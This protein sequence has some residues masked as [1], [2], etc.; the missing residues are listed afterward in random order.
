MR[1]GYGPTLVLLGAAEI[2][3]T[4]P[5]LDRGAHSLDSFWCFMG[6]GM[7]VGWTWD[8]HGLSHKSKHQGEG[9]DSECSIHEDLCQ[10]LEVIQLAV[11]GGA[12]L[13]QA[14]TCSDMFRCRQ[15]F[16]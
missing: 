6:H 4:W 16:G 15:R 13:S 2:Y 9:N 14:H 11:K 7:D 3:C 10:Q 8:G 12:Q 5:K 1:R